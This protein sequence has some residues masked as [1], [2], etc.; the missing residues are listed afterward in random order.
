MHCT[1]VRRHREVRQSWQSYVSSQLTEFTTVL[2]AA[3]AGIPALIT[4]GAAV[5]DALVICAE[6]VIDHVHGVVVPVAAV[7]AS[8]PA[9]VPAPVASVAVP[10]AAE[11]ALVLFLRDIAATTMVTADISVVAAAGH[12]VSD[13]VP[14]SDLYI[15]MWSRQGR[16]H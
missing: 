7:P 1:V 14:I 8:V 9:S 10:E 16:S 12:L 3:F 5:D 6:E 2:A 13:F 11:E 4:P 15:D